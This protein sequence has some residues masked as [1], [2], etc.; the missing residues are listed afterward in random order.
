MGAPTGSD[1]FARAVEVLGIPTIGVIVAVVLVEQFY[2]EIAAG[3]LYLVLSGVILFGVYVAAKYW[4]IPYTGVFVVAGIFIWL[5]VPGVISEITNPVFGILGKV[6]AG[7]FLVGMVLLFVEKL[8]LD[9]IFSG[10]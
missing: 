9:E 4:N 10:W 3:A 7:V 8:G 2:G 5:L 6:V 1:G